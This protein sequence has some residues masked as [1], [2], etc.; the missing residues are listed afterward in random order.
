MFMPSHLQTMTDTRRFHLWQHCTFSWTMQFIKKNLIIL[1]A[2]TKI[3]KPLKHFFLKFQSVFFLQGRNNSR[4]SLLSYNFRGC[5]RA[6][7]LFRTS[8]RVIYSLLLSITESEF[9]HSIHSITICQHKQVAYYIPRFTSGNIL[10]RNWV[11]P[12]LGDRKSAKSWL[13]LSSGCCR[14]FFETEGTKEA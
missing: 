9:N 8:T 2:E 6:E 10:S 11:S 1:L 3:Q 13:L 12:P 7:L 5:E 4:S 14:S